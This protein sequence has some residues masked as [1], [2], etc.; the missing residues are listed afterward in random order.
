MAQEPNQ[1][2]LQGGGISVS[3]F[4]QGQG[5]PVEGSGRLRLSYQDSN[6]SRAFFDNDVRT[7]NVDD[8]GT[9]VS[10]SLFVTVDAGG[11]SFSLLIPHVQLPDQPGPSVF[12]QTQSIITSFTLFD[13][14][15][16]AQPQKQTYTVIALS[17]TAAIGALAN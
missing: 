17:G 1:Y 10:V 15:P 8:L 5:P 14:G 4:P 3:Y 2:H 6:Q 12:I 11:T 7:V 13:F 16:F 9:V